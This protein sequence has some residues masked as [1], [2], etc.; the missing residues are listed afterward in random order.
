MMEMRYMKEAEVEYGWKVFKQSA[1]NFINYRKLINNRFD[2]YISPI[3]GF[4]D[5]IINSPKL[6]KI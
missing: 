5:F 3:Y 4:E 1:F 2:Y 6:T